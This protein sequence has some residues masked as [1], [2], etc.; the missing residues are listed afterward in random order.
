MFSTV[1]GTLVSTHL[2][3]EHFEWELQL[4]YW[5]RFP[6]KCMWKILKGLLISSLKYFGSALKNHFIGPQGNHTDYFSWKEDH[7]S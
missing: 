6:S 7:P 4:A 1:S 3:K 2:L 5:Q